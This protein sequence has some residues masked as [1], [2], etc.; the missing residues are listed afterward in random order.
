MKLSELLPDIPIVVPFCN[1]IDHSLVIEVLLL[2]PSRL[3]VNSEFSP[4]KASRIAG[5]SVE[6]LTKRAIKVIKNK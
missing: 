3:H 1:V 2:P 6:N 5:V 4:S